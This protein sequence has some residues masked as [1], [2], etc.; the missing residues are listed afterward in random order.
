MPDVYVV[1]DFNAEMIARYLT[2]DQSPPICAASCAPYGQLFQTLA[3]PPQLGRDCYGFVWTRPEGAIPD[4]A[5]LLEGHRIAPEVLLARVDDFAASL[6]AFAQP[7]KALFVATWVRSDVSRG[8]GMLD[9][10][11]DGYAYLLAKMNVRLA[12]NLA[13]IKGIYLLDA[14]RWLETA[15]TP[16]RDRKYWFTMKSPFTESVFQTAARDVKAA[17]RGCVGQSRKLVIVDLDDTMW[18]GVVGDQGWQD[19]RLGGHDHIGEAF[20]E[21]Q[22]ALKELTARGIQVGLVSKN[23]ESVA[24]EAIDSHPAMVLRRSDLAG[25]RINW[26]DKAQNLVDLINDLNLGLHSV[27]F[28]DD[29]PTERGRVREALP[30]VLVPDWP[31]DPTRFAETL[32][33][34][35]CFD[36]PALTDEDRA[37]TRMYV[38]D[39]ERKQSGSGFASLDE[40]LLSLDVKI[41][42]APVNGSNLKRTAQ[43]LNKTSQM[44]LSNR[45]LAENE[46]LQWL[47]DRSDRK[48]YAMSVADRFGDLGLTGV[49]TWH[50]GEAGLEIVDFILSC[51][52]MGRKVE[53]TMVHI[54]VEA[55]REAGMP[56]VTARAMPTKRNSPCLDFWHRSGF[57]ETEPNL[58]LWRTSN[59]YPKPECITL[60]RA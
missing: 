16:A 3:A 14:N 45:R 32:R 27:V 41:E 36:Q 39:R 7:L 13:G 43:L 15:R 9:W 8:M 18:G 31:K 17:I 37:R 5:R 10:S 2:T 57:D 28:I 12:E 56:K 44:N 11:Q 38:Q 22:Q 35:D 51:R 26:N 55:A 23:D 19:L 33:M 21:F 47:A 40:W 29:N 24:L 42:I 6:K 50:C 25:W 53:E 59:P 58:F 20:V 34:L 46:L 48:A 54:A 1:S 60:E 4:Y 52:A 49:I 30:D